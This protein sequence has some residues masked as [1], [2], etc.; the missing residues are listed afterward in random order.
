VCLLCKGDV[1][2]PSD[3]YGV[4]YTDMDA[5]DGWKL[6]LAK[7]LKAAGLVFDASKIFE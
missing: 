2:I 4:I 3:L 6:K 7:E 1:E 5:A